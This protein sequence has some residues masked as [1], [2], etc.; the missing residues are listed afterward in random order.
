[1]LRLTR[2]VPIEGHHSYIREKCEKE[3]KKYP[4]R[5]LNQQRYL[6][7]SNCNERLE[8]NDLEELVNFSVI[9]GS[10]KLGINKIGHM[11]DIG[12]SP[13]EIINIYMTRFNERVEIAKIFGQDYIKDYIK[14]FDE[15]QKMPDL[16][17]IIDIHFKP[18]F[19]NSGLLHM[20]L[21]NY[22]AISQKEIELIEENFL[23]LIEYGYVSQDYLL[24]K[25]SLN[26]Y[27]KDYCLSLIDQKK[28]PGLIEI[29]SKKKFIQENSDYYEITNE[30]ILF[31]EEQRELNHKL[32]YK[33]LANEFE[34][35]FNDHYSNEFEVP[36]NDYYFREFEY[37]IF[38]E[39][40]FLHPALNLMMFEID[41][42]QFCFVQ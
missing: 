9:Y 8:D 26:R 1:M 2:D 22:D 40:E 41:E 4:R 29:L 19:G 38:F 42:R 32:N 37:E 21:P 18:Y 17:R 33:I 24:N 14:I 10:Y 11:V 30:G 34:A 27:V 15:R 23:R 20:P 13:D 25:N 35:Q 3:A 12:L 6:I 39:Q 5:K 31:Y 7:K 36:F 28:I 16:F